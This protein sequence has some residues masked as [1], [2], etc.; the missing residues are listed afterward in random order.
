MTNAVASTDVFSALADPTRRHLL[1]LIGG[2]PS[3]VSASALAGRVPVT[4]Q[5]VTQHLAVLEGSGLVARSR[6][7]REVVYTVRPEELISAAG[8][9][10]ARADVWRARLA[11]LK[12]EAEACRVPRV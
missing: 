12:T 10:S 8:W 3:G 4:R 11:A 7:G 5:A 9:L 2:L 1:D 6:R